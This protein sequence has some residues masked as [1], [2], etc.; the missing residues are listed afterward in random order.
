MR[1]ETGRE[2]EKSDR[3]KNHFEMGSKRR[4]IA[5]KLFLIFVVILFDTFIHRLWN[6]LSVLVHSRIDTWKWI[7]VVLVQ[8]FI[9]KNTLLF[10]MKSV[11]MLQAH[12]SFKVSSEMQ[13]RWRKLLT[14]EWGLKPNNN[15]ML[16]QKYDIA[17][18][19]SN[20]SPM[21]VHEN[22][23]PFEESRW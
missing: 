2:K 16:L 17:F 9:S 13:E 10:I 5:V 11:D 3:Q 21:S 12:N 1:V 23:R 20:M 18:A 19:R 8:C 14:S 6:A 7:L 15:T 22:W 4:F